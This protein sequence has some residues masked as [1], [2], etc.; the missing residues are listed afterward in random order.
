MIQHLFGN[1]LTLLNFPIYYE[2]L[3]GSTKC[4]AHKAVTYIAKCQ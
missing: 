2:C 1:V 3:A 4:V